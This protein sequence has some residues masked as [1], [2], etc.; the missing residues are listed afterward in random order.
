MSRPRVGVDFFVAVASMNVAS[1]LVD[2]TNARASVMYEMKGSSRGGRPLLPP[3]TGS[4]M[5][6]LWL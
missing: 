2:L 6:M 5:L 4:P 3:R 1:G